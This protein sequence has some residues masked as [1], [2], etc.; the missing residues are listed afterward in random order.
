MQQSLRYQGMSNISGN[1][2]ARAQRMT[3]Y[4]DRTS[5]KQLSVLEDKVYQPFLISHS[6]ILQFMGNEDKLLS[7]NDIIKSFLDSRKQAQKLYFKVVTRH[8]QELSENPLNLD[9]IIQKNINSSFYA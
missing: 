2:K 5:A 9:Q 1:S 8:K 7:V 6:T 4:P 3:G